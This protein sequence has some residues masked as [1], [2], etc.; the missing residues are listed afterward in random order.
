MTPATDRG[1]GAA[2][3]CKKSPF[4]WPFPQKIDPGAGF[5]PASRRSE[6]RILPI[7]R[8]WN[9]TSGP[10]SAVIPAH[11]ASKDARKR[12]YVAGIHAF[13]LICSKQVVDARHKAHKAHKAGHDA[14]GTARWSV[15]E[16]IE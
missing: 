8:S 12:A 13:L 3:A 1:R 16:R 4:Y 2:E 9:A 5:E 6:R 14:V 11:S 10:L 7:R 15:L